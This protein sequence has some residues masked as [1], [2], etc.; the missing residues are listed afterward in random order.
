MDLKPKKVNPPIMDLIDMIATLGSTSPQIEK[1]INNPIDLFLES[2]TIVNGLKNMNV[3]RGNVFN[4]LKNYGSSVFY[5]GKWSIKFNDEAG[6]DQGGVR[7][8]FFTELAKEL[9]D[10]NY[11]TK[12]STGFHLINQ[13]SS[14]D[15]NIINDYEFIGKLFAYV[16]K[17]HKSEYPNNINLKLHPYLLNALLNS[18]YG[19][20]SHDLTKTYGHNLFDLL[21]A[22]D[23]NILDKIPYIHQFI[24]KELKYSDRKVS[25]TNNSVDLLEMISQ[26]NHN[27]LEEQP[28]SSYVELQ[29]KTKDEW[30]SL[31]KSEKSFCLEQNGFICDG[32][33]E[34]HL[35]I[36]FPYDKKGQ[37]IDFMIRINLH[38]RLIDEFEAFIRGFHSILQPSQMTML[39]MISLNTLIVGE[40]VLDIEEFLA[41][42]EIRGAEPDRKDF[43]LAL[44]R[45]NAI[46]DKTYL[47]E[48][49]YLITGKKTLSVNKYNE[50]G[51]KLEIK[52]I[53]QHMDMIK[54]HT[55]N[56]HV[57]VEFSDKLLNDSTE[58]SSDDLLTIMFKK[59]KIMSV[60]GG[61]FCQAGGAYQTIKLS[62]YNV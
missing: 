59:E 34:E 6:I 36:E 54:P 61:E 33:D 42:F 55:C 44:I 31:T 51:K 26:Y 12:D 2:I 46:E 5:K 52:F 41:K 27:L 4:S 38:Y 10:Q 13:K 18:K 57:N 32:F 8:D 30:T 9:V 40:T 43:I 20:K 19:E 17:S 62:D 21:D 58:K 22:S 24:S 39:N 45:H 25:N 53:N 1:T 60:S 47:N 3:S 50:F 35:K 16:V 14:E 15:T 29:I 49:L 48:L 23:I 56:G 37:F 7:R 28:I 11:F